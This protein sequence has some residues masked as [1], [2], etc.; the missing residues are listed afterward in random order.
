MYCILFSFS[1][2]PDSSISTV[3][4]CAGSGASVLAG[5]KADLYITGRSSQAHIHHR[6]IPTIPST[7]SVCA[8][9]NFTIPSFLII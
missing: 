5:V 4:V 7:A 3:A 8:C 1:S 9:R 2:P 6:I